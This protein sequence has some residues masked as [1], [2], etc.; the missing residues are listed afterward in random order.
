M[1]QTSPLTMVPQNL[2]R[3]G[4]TSEPGTSAL[5]RLHNELATHLHPSLPMNEQKEI[6]HFGRWHTI[7][8]HRKILFCP[9]TPQ[10][11]ALAGRDQI[12][13]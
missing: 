11:R 3:G 12:L 7:H 10:L 2:F 8:W 5:D 9:P 6:T 4:V 13:M 1:I